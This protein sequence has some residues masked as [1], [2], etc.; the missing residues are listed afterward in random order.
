MNF[1]GNSI[2]IGLYA[3][4]FGVL[5]WPIETLIHVL[6]FK[7][8]TFFDAFFSPEVNEAWMRLLTSASFIAFGLY[9]HRAIGQQRELNKILRQQKAR[10]RGVIDSAHDAYISINSASVITDWNPMAEKMFG[11]SRNEAIGKTLLTCIVPERF[12]QHTIMA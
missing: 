8:G 10:V 2:H 7:E 11:W 6:I 3:I 12:H 4:V 5:F 9:T 1:R